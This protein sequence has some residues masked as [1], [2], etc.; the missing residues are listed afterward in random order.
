MFKYQI[1]ILNQPLQTKARRCSL[2][3]SST[4]RGTPLEIEPSSNLMSTIVFSV[5]LIMPA[6]HF[7]SGNLISTWSPTLY[8]CVTA[9]E[10]LT[11]RRPDVARTRRAEEGLLSLNFLNIFLN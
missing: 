3:F 9:C 1:I 5:M 6:Y 7:K 11:G 2:G 8:E 4:I 10:S